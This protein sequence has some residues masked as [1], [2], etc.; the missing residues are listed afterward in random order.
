MIW[1]DILF[2]NGFS[3]SHNIR[4][5]SLINEPLK[6]LHTSNE[7]FGLFKQK[8]IFVFNLNSSPTP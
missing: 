8:K 3:L 5:I 6:K 7:M 1:E 2:E 4:Q